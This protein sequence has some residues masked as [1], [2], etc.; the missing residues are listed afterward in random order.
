M[1][2]MLIPGLLAVGV[3]VV[4]G[5]P[6]AGQTTIHFD[7]GGSERGV[8]VPGTR[9]FVFMGSTWTGGVVATERRPPL[10]ASGAFSYEVGA[11]G[12][13][14][15]FEPP[16]D[17]ITFFFVHGLGFSAGTA[18]AFDGAGNAVGTV[19]SR[20]ATTFGN[21]ANFVTL[22]GPPAIAR[23]EVSGA[24]VDDFTFVTAAEPSATPPPTPTL[25]PRPVSC[26][27]DCNGDGTVSI[28][29]LIRG[30]TLALSTSAAD[31]CPGLDRGGDGIVA[32]DDLVAAVNAALAGCVA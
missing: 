6:A 24:V 16:V 7:N 32:I 5:T 13:G 29:E 22:T 27:G 17:S 8:T 19:A 9:E 14:V 28:D 4:V 26:P 20:A 25:P 30:V 15:A 12:A 1:P 3:A 21:P 10:Y 31:A 11:R 23:I 18:T 2:R